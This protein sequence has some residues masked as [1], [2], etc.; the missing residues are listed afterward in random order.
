MIIY[1][2][3]DKYDIT[4]FMNE[5]PG[6]SNVFKDGED[7]TEEF[8]DVHHSREAM[9]R[10]NEFKIDDSSSNE[11]L[12]EK[13][14]SGIKIED[15]SI[16]DFL[17]SKFNA[18]PLRKLF[19]KEDKANMHKILGVV[20]LLVYAWYY[21][22][23]IKNGSTY[24]IPRGRTT[25]DVVLSMLPAALLSI[26]SLQFNLANNFTMNGFGLLNNEFRNVNGIFVIRSILLGAIGYL[27]R[28]KPNAHVIFVWAILMMNM[29][30]REKISDIANPDGITPSS[31]VRSKSRFWDSCPNWFSENI[32]TFYSGVQITA[33]GCPLLTTSLYPNISAI[34]VLQLASFSATLLKKGFIGLF[35]WH[36]IYIFTYI[37]SFIGLFRESPEPALYGNTGLLILS[38]IAYNLRVNARITRYALWTLAAIALLSWRNGGTKTMVISVIMAAVIFHLFGKLQDPPRKAS[39]FRDIVKKNTEIIPNIFK[40]DISLKQDTIIKPGQFVKLFGN[41]KSSPYTPVDWSD[42]SLMLYIKSYTG[43]ISEH[44]CRSWTNN[45]DAMLDGPYGDNY[46]DPDT[47]IL[48]TKAGVVPHGE[49][50]MF[51]CGTGIAPF[52]AIVTHLSPDTK[53]NFRIYA[54]FSSKETRFLLDNIPK[55]VHKKLFYSNLARIAQKDIQTI[56]KRR[57]NKISAI[58]ICGTPD[59]SVMVQSSVSE[60]KPSTLIVK[61]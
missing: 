39:D 53:Y 1:I 34:F 31:T 36:S 44:I 40:L 14:N 56:I 38:I 48:H 12:S 7:L 54:S 32:R 21:F 26:S 29:F 35:G 57:S 37:I 10:L 18:S 60:I 17:K 9:T 5:H 27:F 61:W 43:G 6:G 23:V 8:E 30:I 49:I 33:S 51:C 3:N 50:I 19:T 47:D 42:R 2:N 22:G 45:S 41:D 58:L 15:V 13:E 52:N 28:N 24:G 55:Y 11:V 16:L 46:Y 20:S 25:L 4:E 59:Y